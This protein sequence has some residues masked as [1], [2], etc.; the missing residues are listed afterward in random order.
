MG[1]IFGTDGMRGI[2]NKDL[3]CELAMNIGRAAAAALTSN[4]HKRP[5]ILIGK[6]TRLSSNMLEGALQAGICSVG[7]N[8]AL[9]GVVPTPAVAYLVKKY[10]ADAGI[11]ISASHNSYE[12]NGIK[13]F[14]RNGYKLPDK[15]ENR[16]EE[17]LEIG[18]ES[19]KN[20]IGDKLGNVSTENNAA[21]DYILHLKNAVNNNFCG[22]KVAV[23]CSN[24]CACTTARRLF[25]GL[26]AD[27][28]IIFDSP[29]GININDNCGSTHLERL[30]EYVKNNDMDLGIAFDGDADRCLAVDENGETVNGD[31]IMAICAMYMKENNLLSKNT[32]VGTTMTNMGFTDFCEK[33]GIKFSSTE[34]GDR[35]VLEEMLSKG[36]NLGGE[37][38]GHM[39][40]LD[41][42]TTGDGQLTALWLLNILHQ[43]KMKLSEISKIVTKYPQSI[44]NL[45]VSQK[46]K[47]EF[48]CN[49]NVNKIIFDSEEKLGDKGRVVIRESG[50][51]PLI[52]IM[53]E[54]IDNILLEEVISDICIKLNE[55]L[56][57]LK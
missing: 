50:T 12:F 24:G 13:I 10:K 26:K 31:T 9:L 57:K 20:P 41:Y 36:Y 48:N 27:C 42:S 47:T 44:L 22:I 39:I 33:E 17:L 4:K 19:D 1:R 53:V 40:L 5:K 52:R 6:D 38:S 29:D 51:E 46:Q 35:Y 32:V 43:K 45:E 55:L 8:A 16:I 25:T 54:C 11:M 15:I 18:F 23:D 56:K 7:A 34:V 37:Q 30:S 28:R 49:E 2:A 14:D 3:T 21:E